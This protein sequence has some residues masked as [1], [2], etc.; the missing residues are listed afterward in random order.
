MQG[1]GWATS[2]ELKYSSRGELLTHS[3]TT[4]KIPNIG[5]LPEVFNLGFLENTESS[6]SL[7]RSKALGEPP[8]LLAISVWTA[9]KKAVSF[10]SRAAASGLR[11]PAS[12]ETLLLAMEEPRSR[13][14]SA[15]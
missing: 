3:P 13:P 5:D 9:A 15:R 4:Y 7:L 14:A 2:E 10:V 6:V 12:G 1:L 8:L 11:L